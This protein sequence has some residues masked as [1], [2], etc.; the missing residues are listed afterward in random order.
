MMSDA[1]LSTVHADLGDGSG[2]GTSSPWGFG[3]PSVGVG[4]GQQQQQ[5]PRLVAQ[6]ADDPRAPSVQNSIAMGKGLYEGRV[7]K[8]S[9]IEVIPRDTFGDGKKCFREFFPPTH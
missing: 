6:G 1:I 7:G 3:S 8:Q 4:G 9:V 5:Q 2:V